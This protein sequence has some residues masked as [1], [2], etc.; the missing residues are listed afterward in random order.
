MGIKIGNTTYEKISEQ[1]DD[2]KFKYAGKGVQDGTLKLSHYA[3]EGNTGYYFY[4]KL[5]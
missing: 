3:V 1:A 5:K 4:E 2:I